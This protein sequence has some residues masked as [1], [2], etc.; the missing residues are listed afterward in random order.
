MSDPERAP[1]PAWKRRPQTAGAML[2]LKGYVPTVLVCDHCQKSLERAE[3]Y[4][5]VTFAGREARYPCP[6]CGRA[7]VRTLRRSEGTRGAP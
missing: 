6:H 4:V 5:D 1:M 3:G 2:L 7:S